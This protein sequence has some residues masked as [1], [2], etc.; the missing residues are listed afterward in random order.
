[1]QRAASGAR[2]HGQAA[3]T[4]GGRRRIPPGLSD[5]AAHPVVPATRDVVDCAIPY[6]RR[7]LFHNIVDFDDHLLDAAANWLEPVLPP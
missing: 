6:V 4:H 5:D 2:E 7:R 3:L 1:M